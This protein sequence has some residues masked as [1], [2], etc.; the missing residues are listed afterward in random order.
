MY[1][2]CQFIFRTPPTLSG[3]FCLFG[4]RLCT[5]GGYA[6]AHTI[7]LAQGALGRDD[8]RF[9]INHAGGARAILTHHI[10]LVSALP[11]LTLLLG[12]AGACGSRLHIAVDPRLPSQE[13]RWNSSP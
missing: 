3:I 5:S 9:S 6:S 1:V 13:F 8:D 2:D 12:A 10:G 11:A 7:D 4:S